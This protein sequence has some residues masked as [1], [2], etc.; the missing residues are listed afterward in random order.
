MLRECSKEVGESGQLVQTGDETQENEEGEEQ[1]QGASSS[2][3]EM[4]GDELWNRRGLRT[5]EEPKNGR[6]CG[7]LRCQVSRWEL[8]Q[9]R[10]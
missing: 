9:L 6:Q 7:S 5:L 3:K 8:S 2:G 10:A 4:A 1:S